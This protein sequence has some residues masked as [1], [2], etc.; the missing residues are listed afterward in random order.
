MTAKADFSDQEWQTVI[1]GPPTAGVLVITAQ[2]GGTFRETIAMGKAYA[3][4]RAQ[5]G[6]SELLDEIVSARPKVDHTRFSS[7]QELK[8]H[9]LQ[10]LGD[11]VEV[12]GRKASPDEL[13]DYR[14]FVI[15]LAERVA[16]AHR[17]DGAEVGPA[18]Q[19]AIDEISASLGRSAS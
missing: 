7:A 9:G 3:E 2:R 6:A 5:H 1:E 8:Q 18:E 14:R 13:D 16:H 15:A 12:L 11:A 19:A 10:L 17:E 4:A